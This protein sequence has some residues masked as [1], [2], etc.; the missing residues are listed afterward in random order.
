LDR[1]GLDRVLQLLALDPS[2][3]GV[4]CVGFRPD[5][6][7][8]APR[9]V[10]PHGVLTGRRTPW[11]YEPGLLDGG[12][13]FLA[14]LDVLPAETQALLAQ[15]LD[16]GGCVLLASA[17][18]APWEH[19][20][21]R[22]AFLVTK[23]APPA[24]QPVRGNLVSLPQAMQ[25]LA[26]TA[27]H[28]ATEGHRA[29][30]FALAAARA[31]ARADGRRRLCEGDLAEAAALVLAPRARRPEQS[32][33]QTPDQGRTQTPGQR[34]DPGQNQSAPPL[35]AA[36]IP[37]PGSRARVRPSPL[38]PPVRTLPGP[39][40]HGALDLPATLLAALPWRSIRAER[41]LPPIIPADLRW[42]LHKV[43]QGRLVI[44][45]VDGSGSMGRRRL[46]QAKG[47]VLRLLHQAYRSRDQVA[48]IVAAGP[49]AHLLLPPARAVEQARR[50]LTALPA[51]GGTPLAS[52]L[53]LAQSLADRVRQK[54]NREALLILLTDGRANQPLSGHS[55]DP[56][57]IREELKRLALHLRQRSTRSVVCSEPGNAEASD[58]AH[59]LGAPLQP[60]NPAA[61]R[62]S[63]VASTCDMFRP[64]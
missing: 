13:T 12:G 40:R 17:T 37:L 50:A 14:D 61:H 25:S 34:P 26:E 3:G 7:P 31:I 63:S 57:A 51:G 32:Q 39:R 33:D 20:A 4:I 58:L 1:A 5:S 53:R 10:P 38:G 47:A 18:E 55:G 19:L 9:R 59:W 44:F 36:P 28:L 45:A 24:P 54:E 6:W 8:G 42:H 30:A 16:A 35:Q 56:A 48:L 27:A 15:R 2:L 60:I 11:G 46:G 21:G 41:S 43:K 64:R 52:A 49:T 29:E 62:P 22:V 23:Q